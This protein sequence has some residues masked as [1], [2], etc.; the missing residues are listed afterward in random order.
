M[1]DFMKIGCCSRIEI[2]RYLPEAT[3][4]KLAKDALAAIPALG[5]HAAGLLIAI[6]PQLAPE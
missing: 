3:R 1:D 5:R 4:E 6:S 2:A